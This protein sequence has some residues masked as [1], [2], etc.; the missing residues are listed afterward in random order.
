MY[1]LTTSA[2]KTE[3][4]TREKE[5]RKRELFDRREKTLDQIR[6]SGAYPLSFHSGIH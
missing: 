1:T 6:N 2:S 5:L 3:I 4:K